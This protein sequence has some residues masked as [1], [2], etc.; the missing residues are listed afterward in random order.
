[1][2]YRS[3]F[4]KCV[5]AFTCVV[6]FVSG[7][8]AVTESVVSS[9]N[10]GVLLLGIAAIGGGV[11]GV[12]SFLRY[13]VEI[14]NVGISKVDIVHRCIKWDD[15]NEISYWGYDI[16]I[17]AKNT[18]LSLDRDLKDRKRLLMMVVANIDRERVRLT[19]PGWIDWRVHST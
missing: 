4:N 19:G 18:R 9:I 10:M 5:L 16:E 2:F 17:R 15:I 12:V 6:L 8:Y 13:R 7:S 14:N 11:I 3:F 1:M